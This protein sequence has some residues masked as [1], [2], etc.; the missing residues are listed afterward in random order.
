[1]NYFSKKWTQL[2]PDKKWMHNCRPF[3]KKAKIPYVNVI[4]SLFGM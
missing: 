4:F 2:L 1:M 3:V